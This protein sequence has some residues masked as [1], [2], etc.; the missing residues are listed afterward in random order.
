MFKRS[1]AVA[2]AVVAVTVASLVALR[3]QDNPAPK[4]GV[5]ASDPVTISADVNGKTP[6][7]AAMPAIANGP[8]GELAVAYGAKFGGIVTLVVQ[9]SDDGGAS[10][11]EPEAL[12]GPRDNAVAANTRGPRIAWRPDGEIVVTAF[13]KLNGTDSHLY[14]YVQTKRGG[15]WDAARVTDGNAKD[16]E[17][18]HAMAMNADG[19]FIVIWLDARNGQQ[20][21]WTAT[22]KDG[23]RWRKHTRLYASPTGSICECCT[24]SLA[25]SADGELIVAQFRNQIRQGRTPLRDT[26][27]TISRDGGKS[28]DAIEAGDMDWP[29]DGCPMDGGEVAVLDS[30]HIASVYRVDDRCYL[31]IVTIPESKRDDPTASVVEL[32]G[33]STFFP[34]VAALP[35]GRALVEWQTARTNATMKLA[36]Y[37]P[38][39]GLTDPI[40][41]NSLRG[42]FATLH[43][44]P[45]NDDDDDD[46]SEGGSVRALM[47]WEAVDGRAR[48]LNASTI[49]VTLADGE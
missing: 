40:E 20:E 3:A 48:V 27:L 21:L 11:S 30:T 5:S 34:R 28:F 22:S 9:T 6:D 8:D 15:K 35:D 32:P 2:L 29:I 10:W 47:V 23:E 37:D 18:M 16:A 24:P 26:W 44:L 19:E 31:A 33:S 45:A 46:D 1:L 38:D 36:V 13:V 41:S 43:A 39:S 14:S 4:I 42:G 12:T 25:M 49:T 17:S 7:S